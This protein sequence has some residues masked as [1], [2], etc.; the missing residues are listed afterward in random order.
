MGTKLS[1]I[2]SHSG[3]GVSVQV[4]TQLVDV[5]SGIP[6]ILG[7]AHSNRG[8]QTHNLWEWCWFRTQLDVQVHLHD[9]IVGV[10]LHGVVAFI[11]E[12]EGEC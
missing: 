6:L 10:V 9:C 4:G 5:L 3:D 8:C 7:L 1:L 12:N 11:K 2:L